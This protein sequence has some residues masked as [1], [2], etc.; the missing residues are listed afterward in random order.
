MTDEQKRILKQKTMALTNPELLAALREIKKS[1]KPSAQVTADYIN[2]LMKARLIVPVAMTDAEEENKLQVKF[3][4]VTNNK[5]QKYF[6]AFTDIETLK[7]SRNDIDKMQFL[8]LTY[9]DFAGM[10]SDPKCQMEGFAINPFTEN[11]II[12]PQQ[13]RAIQG[14]IT[15]QRVRNGELAVIE[16]IEDPPEELTRPMESYFEDRGDVKKAYMMELR[17]GDHVNLLLV[18][19]TEAEDFEQ[20][21]SDFNEKLLNGLN[22][23]NKPFVVMSFAEEAGKQATH[24]KV[25]FYVKI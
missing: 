15:S 13:A 21:R 20:F 4:H 7:K 10:L 8:G 16:E 2:A 9:N 22:D 19:D 18:V 1:P 24:E 25:P 14:I 11:I 23:E 5:G 12:G 6:M 3:S 17:K